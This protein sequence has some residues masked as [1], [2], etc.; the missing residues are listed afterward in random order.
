M[1]QS[2]LRALVAQ[3]GASQGPAPSG[4]ASWQEVA[5]NAAQRPQPKPMGQQMADVLGGVALPCA[6]ALRQLMPQQ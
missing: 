2:A 1:A 5:Q 4:M 3:L 6:P